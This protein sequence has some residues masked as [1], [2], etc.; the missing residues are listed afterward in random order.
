MSLL[1]GVMP[2]SPTTFHPDESLD[3][4]SQRR[5]YDFLIDAGVD[6]VCILAN[7]SEQ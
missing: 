6:A 1:R 5:V 4:V 7:Y 3:L 2:I